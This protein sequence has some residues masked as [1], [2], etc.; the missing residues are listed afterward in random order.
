MTTNIDKSTLIENI[1]RNFFDRVKDQVTSVTITTEPYTVTIQGYHNTFSDEL[2]DTKSNYPFII[3]EDPKI[4]TSQFT[5]TRTEADC[6]I[7]IEVYTT[8]SESASKFFSKILDTIET[9]KDDLAD[10]GISKIDIDMTDSDMFQRGTIK[11]HNRSVRFNFKY[12][13]DRTKAH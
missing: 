11:V 12:R 4:S 8:Q 6:N 9:Y 10:V 1:W 7:T 13:Y 2:I 3:V 5:M